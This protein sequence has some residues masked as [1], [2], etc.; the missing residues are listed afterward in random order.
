MALCSSLCALI[1]SI[2]FSPNVEY[3]IMRSELDEWAQG[4]DLRVIDSTFYFS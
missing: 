2:E 4:A 3:G 1:V